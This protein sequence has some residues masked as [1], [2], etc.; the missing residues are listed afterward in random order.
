MSK[1]AGL[2]Q[3]IGEGYL[4]EWCSDSTV[5]SLSPQLWGLV[6]GMIH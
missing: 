6:L 4:D 1:Q 3:S 2:K 5:L